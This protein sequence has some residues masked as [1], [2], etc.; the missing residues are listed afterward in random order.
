MQPQ[1]LSQ[2]AQQGC[3]APAGPQN[4][5]G[6]FEKIIKNSVNAHCRCH[7]GRSITSIR[8][9]CHVTS[10]SNEG[11]NHKCLHT[12]KSGLEGILHCGLRRC[13]GH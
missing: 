8:A 1:V 9:S 2:R 6:T 5:H 10:H 12:S 7:V 3:S 11:S 13:Q 4:Q